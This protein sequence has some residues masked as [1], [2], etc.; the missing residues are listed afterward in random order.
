M[1]FI[2]KSEHTFSSSNFDEKENTIEIWDSAND[3]YI[4][5]PVESGFK[6]R[7]ANDSIASH[8]ENDL[9]LRIERSA[10]APN[11]LLSRNRAV[12][13]RKI[14]PLI[15]KPYSVLVTYVTN[16]Y[17]EITGLMTYFIPIPEEGS[18]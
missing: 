13:W 5:R 9:L 14:I 1:Y 8:R 12:L 10:N 16:P 6:F 18:R 17:S 3:L 4:C 2:D 11:I 7:V 15:L